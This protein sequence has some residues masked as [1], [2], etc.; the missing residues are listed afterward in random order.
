VGGVRVVME[1]AA[2]SLVS[3]RRWGRKGRGLA[4]ALALA[5]DLPALEP[6]PPPYQRFSASTLFIRHIH[7]SGWAPL[8]ICLTHDHCCIGCAG[9]RTVSI[10]RSGRPRA[11]L[12]TAR[13]KGLQRTSHPPS[14]PMKYDIF[15]PFWC[16]KLAYFCTSYPDLGSFSVWPTNPSQTSTPYAG[17]PRCCR[18]FCYWAYVEIRLTVEQ[19]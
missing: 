15:Q 1:M 8:T 9:S 10:S 12:A 4:L 7:A 5:P 3:S 16:K 18:A 14:S 6:Q 13:S 2:S 11:R 17:L 19:F